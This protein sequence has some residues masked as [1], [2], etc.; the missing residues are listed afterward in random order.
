MPDGSIRIYY[1]GGDDPHDGLRNESFALATMRPDM[2]SRLS[3]TGTAKTI[4][5]TPTGTG[6]TPP[7]VTA[8][9]LAP[10][11]WLP[12]APSNCGIHHHKAR[13][14]HVVETNVT[15][16]VVLEGL[17]VGKA[18]TLKLLMQDTMLYTLG[19]AP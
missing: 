14:N 8:D 13:D 7:H 10:S 4:T 3:G 9:V 17:N 16:V 2:V 18:V 1:M 5:L 15:D 19:F 6:R 11:W 12:H